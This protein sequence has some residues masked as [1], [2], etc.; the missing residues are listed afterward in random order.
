M[1]LTD[2]R[3]RLHWPYY[4]DSLAKL[5]PAKELFR[6]FQSCPH[7]ERKG[8]YPFIE[9]INDVAPVISRSDGETFHLVLGD[10]PISYPAEKSSGKTEMVTAG[11]W[12]VKERDP[13]DKGEVF[14]GT[15]VVVLRK[16]PRGVEM[17]RQ[18]ETVADRLVEK[19]R[20]TPFVETF[21]EFDGD[22]LSKI[23]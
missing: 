6:N 20:K 7:C 5:K 21:Y 3:L 18:L 19:I 4:R 1:S 23:A 10:R 15:V 8:C 14:A 13:E 17:L 22:R 11:F 9:R 16:H 2:F 12:Y